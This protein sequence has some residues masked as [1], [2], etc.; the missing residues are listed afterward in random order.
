MIQFDPSKVPPFTTEF[1][2]AQLS[3]AP[4]G[5]RANSIYLGRRQL[6]ELEA[7]VTAEVR[8]DLQRNGPF[9]LSDTD[10]YPVEAESHFLVTFVEVPPTEHLLDDLLDYCLKLN[11]AQGC[12]PEFLD[13]VV[14]A[15]RVKK[16]LEKEGA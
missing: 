11:T 14:R 1:L 16:S 5:T 3:L 2:N 6:D 9:K 4:A 13:I 12:P 7:S 10:V 8:S 15:D